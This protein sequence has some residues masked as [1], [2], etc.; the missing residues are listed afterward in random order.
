MLIETLY[1]RLAFVYV[2]DFRLSSSVNTQ[3]A[4]SSLN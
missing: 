1:E 4:D 3:I 2:D